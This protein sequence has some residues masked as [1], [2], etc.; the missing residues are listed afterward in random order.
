MS[1]YHDRF[2]NG[3]LFGT[4]ALT[5]GPPEQAFSG[6]GTNA[7]IHGNR[8]LQ[9]SRGGTHAILD[10][11]KT[12]V[13]SRLQSLNSISGT[14]EPYSIIII[15]NDNY[16]IT[17]MHVGFYLYNAKKALIFDPGGSYRPQNSDPALNVNPRCNY[18]WVPEHGNLTDYMKYQT[19]DGPDVRSF[20]FQLS[21][22]EYT[23]IVD[24][25]EST[26]FWDPGECSDGVQEVL[27]G[28][29]PFKSLPYSRTPAGLARELKK[30]QTN[31]LNSQK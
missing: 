28:V 21:L 5:G 16:P 9:E 14:S 26:H 27:S 23:T 30:L 6:G 10:M 2:G 12:D 8:P 31:V 17:G 11:E 22:D 1:L 4:L 7:I 3:A 19:D 13:R 29:G 20:W 15:V 25:V 18:L 24:R